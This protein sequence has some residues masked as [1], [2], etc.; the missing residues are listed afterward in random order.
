MRRT[1]ILDKWLMNNIKVLPVHIRGRSQLMS[2]VGWVELTINY[3]YADWFV[4]LLVSF[5]HLSFL[6]SWLLG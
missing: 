3:C 4:I 1:V 6:V 2:Y 5:L